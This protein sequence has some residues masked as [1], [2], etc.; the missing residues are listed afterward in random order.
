MEAQQY[1]EV[2]LIEDRFEDAELAI[3][4]L[5]EGGL[6]NQI[7]LLKDGQEALD[8]LFAEGS[9]EDVSPGLP[10]LIFL[11]LKLP[12]VSGME[13]LKRLK[14]SEKHK[15]VP[16]VVLTSS[17]EDIDIEKAYDLGANSYIVK[18]VD[19]DN[20]SNAVRQVGLYWVVLNTSP[21]S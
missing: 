11:D 21:N 14:T 12:K 1:I 3:D 7:K 18:P 4:S 17:K 13:V 10:K 9:Y 20:F 16:V 19:F 8:Y 6:I 2:L 5:R 15:H